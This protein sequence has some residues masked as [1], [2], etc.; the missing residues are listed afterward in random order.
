MSWHSTVTKDGVVE[1]RCTF[2]STGARFAQVLVKIRMEGVAS[3]WRYYK[4]DPDK[5]PNIVISMNGTAGLTFEQWRE[6]KEAI[7]K[8]VAEAYEVFAAEQ[9]K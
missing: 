4:P 8:G 2:N 3:N 7:D 1:L 9:Q 5:D 6:M